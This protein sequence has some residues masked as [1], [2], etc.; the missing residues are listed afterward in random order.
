MALLRN[1]LGLIGVA[2]G[3][4]DRLVADE[5]RISVHYGLM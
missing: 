5:Q 4:G 1:A 2:V 3:F